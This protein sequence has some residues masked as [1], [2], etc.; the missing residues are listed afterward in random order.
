MISA[1]SR[2]R[3][4][5]TGLEAD[6]SRQRVAPAAIQTRHRYG[7]N[8]RT[9]GV[10]EQER[11]PMLLQGVFRREGLDGDIRCTAS[12]LSFVFRDNPP[13][14]ESGW[15]M[16]LLAVV[17]AAGNLLKEVYRV[18]DA[19]ALWVDFWGMGYMTTTV[20]KAMD[21]ARRM[22]V[23]IITPEEFWNTFEIQP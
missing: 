7:W 5:T 10:K 14:F 22:G 17:I 1:I 15:L 18:E 6:M 16:N 21:F 20:G 23:G 12:E 3:K 11:V 19:Y 13:D 8:Y 9:F 4:D 2:I